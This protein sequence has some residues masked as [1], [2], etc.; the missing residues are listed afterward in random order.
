MTEGSLIVSHLF[1]KIAIYLKVGGILLT[2]VSFSFYC[3]FSELGNG[4][5][6]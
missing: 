1:R 5:P 3:A 4:S 2:G 6:I